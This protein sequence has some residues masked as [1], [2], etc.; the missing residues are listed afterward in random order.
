[1]NVTF[2]PHVHKVLITRTNIEYNEI[3]GIG[4]KSSISASQAEGRE[5]DPPFP[6]LII[7][8][9]LFWLL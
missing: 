4:M 6:L 7:R 2:Q 9:L 8:D 1:T 3:L 5:F